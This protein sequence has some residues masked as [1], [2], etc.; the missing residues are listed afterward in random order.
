MTAGAI[1][2]RHQP[3]THLLD[4]W[5]NGRES[6]VLQDRVGAVRHGRI[7]N[8]VAHYGWTLIRHV[9]QRIRELFPEYILRNHMACGEE[10]EEGEQSRL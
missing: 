4:E 8:V 2:F 3:T 1:V 7:L 5:S 9:V 6:T 10:G